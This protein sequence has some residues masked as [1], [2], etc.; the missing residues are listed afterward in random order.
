MT[1]GARFVSFMD[2]ERPLLFVQSLREVSAMLVV[3]GL[4]S[5]AIKLK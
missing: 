1:I 4:I 5:I 3:V 2:R